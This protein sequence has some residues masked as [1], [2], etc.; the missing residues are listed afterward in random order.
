VAG[1]LLGTALFGGIFAIALALFHHR[2]Q[3]TLTNMGRLIV[4][5]GVAGLLPHPEL[6]LS[7]PGTLRL[8]YGLAIAA[9]AG[10][11]LCSVLLR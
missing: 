10:S 9:G 3:P 11:S 2:L 6:N 8:P 5:H 1:I 4:H 7:N